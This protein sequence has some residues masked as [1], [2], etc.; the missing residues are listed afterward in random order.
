M[1]CHTQKR[2]VHRNHD[3]E[4]ISDAIIASIYQESMIVTTFE[5]QNI[6]NFSSWQQDK[7]S[8]LKINI[9]CTFLLI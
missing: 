3:G 1:I 7:L 2:E 6:Y 4:F 9:N 8:Q 5:N